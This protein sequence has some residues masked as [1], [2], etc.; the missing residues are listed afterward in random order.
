MT[1]AFASVTPLTRS[2]AYARSI[3]ETDC[4]VCRQSSFNVRSARRSV[5]LSHQRVQKEQDD[6]D[7]STVPHLPRRPSN[8]CCGIIIQETLSDEFVPTRM[9]T[10]N[11]A[12]WATSKGAMT[13]LIKSKRRMETIAV[14]APGGRPA[15][16]GTN[17]TRSCALMGLRCCRRPYLE[18]FQ[19]LIRSPD[20]TL[21]VCL[22]HTGAGFGSV[23]SPL[24]QNYVLTLD[25]LLCTTP[26]TTPDAALFSMLVP[27]ASNKSSGM[28]T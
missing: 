20:I 8:H 9:R 12:N 6:C 23:C 25:E 17:Q 21:I 10:S 4:A 28:N 15:S 1:V 2:D 18:E 11:T 26:V 13:W 3:M 19:R 27:I 24:R 22:Y 5:R 14:A 16:R 7:H